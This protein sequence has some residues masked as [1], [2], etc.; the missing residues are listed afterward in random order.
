MRAFDPQQR[1]PAC[2][3][4]DAAPY[5]EP[6]SAREACK[7]RVYDC[8]MTQ[9]RFRAISTPLY[10]QPSP[11]ETQTED[12]VFALQRAKPYLLKVE[13]KSKSRFEMKFWQP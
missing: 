7:K 6:F 2:V 3:P 8:G 9:A 10:I 4:T 1:F 5:Y 13:E 11:V 12:G